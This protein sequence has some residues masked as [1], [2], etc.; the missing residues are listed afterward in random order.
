[1]VRLTVSMLLGS[2]SNVFCRHVYWAEGKGAKAS[3]GSKCKWERKHSFKREGQVGKR[4]FKC[5]GQVGSSIKA[6]S[7]SMF[8]R[9][10]EGS[11]LRPIGQKACKLFHRPYTL[12]YKL[13][14]N[15]NSI[16]TRRPSGAVL[17]TRSKL[18]SQQRTTF[19]H[20]T[21]LKRAGPGY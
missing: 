7:R 17:V 21:P 14:K 8:S 11:K 19:S 16:P 5:K 1:M 13:F 15:P 6:T 10:S 2:G 12:T 20:D 4:S 3:Q 9:S 18:L